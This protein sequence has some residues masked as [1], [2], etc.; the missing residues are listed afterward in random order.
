MHNVSLLVPS[1]DTTCGNTGVMAGQRQTVG[2]LACFAK[3]QFLAK[4]DQPTQS[5]ATSWSDPE[6]VKSYFFRPFDCGSE[7]EKREKRE[8]VRIGK[9]AF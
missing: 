4:E 5:R 2:G 7:R 9:H 3:V 6:Y 1:T 8:R